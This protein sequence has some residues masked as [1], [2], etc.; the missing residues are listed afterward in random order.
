[1]TTKQAMWWKLLGLALLAA[2]LMAPLFVPL[3][4]HAVMIDPARPVTATP[5]PYAWR[6]LQV[7]AYADILAL[8]CVGFAAWRVVRSARKPQA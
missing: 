2:V 6:Y 7:A 8:A 1:M 5:M 3:P 4:T